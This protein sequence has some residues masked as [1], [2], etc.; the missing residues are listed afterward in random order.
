MILEQKLS[1]ILFHICNNFTTISSTHTHVSKPEEKKAVSTLYCNK[2]QNTW[3]SSPCCIGKC[4]LGKCWI[5]IGRCQLVPWSLKCLALLGLLMCSLL[6]RNLLDHWGV[7]FTRARHCQPYHVCYQECGCDL[8]KP[9]DLGRKG[10]VPFQSLVLGARLA[11]CD[12][13]VGLGAEA[14]VILSSLTSL[15]GMF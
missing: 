12:R 5:N 15:S 4:C 6:M 9:R 7:F 2:C 11:Q 3:G 8:C 14:R 10:T 13:K 1:N